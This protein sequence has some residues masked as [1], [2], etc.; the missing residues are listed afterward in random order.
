[1]DNDN[2]KG[3]IEIEMKI[4][5]DWAESIRSKTRALDFNGYDSPNYN[6]DA[7]KAILLE[8]LDFEDRS[9]SF[10]S[11]Y[12]TYGDIAVSININI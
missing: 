8:Y 11:V 4:I 10:E 12:F 9:P 6:K 2:L 1:M 7:Y 3:K 5:I